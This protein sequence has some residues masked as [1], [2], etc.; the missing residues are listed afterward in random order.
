MLFRAQKLSISEAMQTISSVVPGSTSTTDSIY[1]YAYLIGKSNFIEI[2]A[3]EQNEVS[4]MAT[5]DAEVNEDFNILFPI[6]KVFQLVKLMGNEITVSKDKDRLLFESDNS[7]HRIA[8]RSPKD[9]PVPISSTDQGLEIPAQV[10]KKMLNYVSCAL[11]RFDQG[12]WSLASVYIK[13]ENRELRIYTC[14]GTQAARA[15]YK[16]ESDTTFDGLLP[17][18]SLNPIMKILNFRDDELIQIIPGNNKMEFRTFRGNLISRTRINKFPPVDRLI[19]EKL[20]YTMNL[21]KKELTEALA[22]ILL[23]TT[24]SAVNFTVKDNGLKLENVAVAS[25]DSREL[26]ELSNSILGEVKFSVFGNHLVSAIREIDGNVDV[27]FGSNNQVMIKSTDLTEF[28]FQY[29]TATVRGD[30]V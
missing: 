21:N 6:K 28:D 3:V 27:D 5:F 18:G 19:P 1:Q 4:I 29:V 8:T 11:S 13:A 14:D 24:D 9:F 26:L 2:Y 10:F 15:V 17:M 25:G 22:R 20:D 23:F 16:I 30:E 12:N 7:K